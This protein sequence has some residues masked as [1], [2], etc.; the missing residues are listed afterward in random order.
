VSVTTSGLRL[1][2]SVLELVNNGVE[3]GVQ[4]MCSAQ[5]QLRRDK[6]KTT[7]EGDHGR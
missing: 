2:V 4:Q 5:L 3:Y 6:N 1:V 7:K